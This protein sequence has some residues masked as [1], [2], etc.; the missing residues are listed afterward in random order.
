MPLLFYVQLACLSLNDGKPTLVGVL[1]LMVLYSIMRLLKLRIASL[2]GPET[3]NQVEDI[4]RI[5]GARWIRMACIFRN[6]T[7]L[8]EFLVVLGFHQCTMASRM[9]R[10]Q[11]P[12]QLQSVNGKLLWAYL[13]R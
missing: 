13:P 8:D 4:F 6:T 12:A 7:T 3:L 10:P 2:S 9:L 11:V 1:I 5:D